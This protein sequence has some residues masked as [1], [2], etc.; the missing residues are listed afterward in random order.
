MTYNQLCG[1]RFKKKRKIRT[2]A[3][4]GCPQRRGVCLRIFITTPKKP[5]SGLRKTV[6]IRLAKTR[7][8]LT[9]S[10]PGKG[11]S[12]I[13]Y[14]SVLVRG[15]RTRDLPGVHYKVVRGVYD[16]HGVINRKKSRSK[17]GTKKKK[18]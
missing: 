3:L 2:K 4:L 6:R 18:A 1:G 16:L 13:Q 14:S 9:A 15:G 10:I 5:H 11:H 7:K 17:Y 12:L 8:H